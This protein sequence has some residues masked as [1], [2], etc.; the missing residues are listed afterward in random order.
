MFPKTAADNAVRIWRAL[1]IGES[2][3]PF[4]AAESAR[5]QENPTIFATCDWSRRSWRLFPFIQ[6]HKGEPK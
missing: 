2:G 4:V 5:P 1:W 3:N 6:T